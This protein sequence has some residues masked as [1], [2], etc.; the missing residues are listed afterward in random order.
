MKNHLYKGV[1]QV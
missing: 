1:K